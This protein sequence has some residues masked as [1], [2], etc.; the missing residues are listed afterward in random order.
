MRV[1]FSDDGR[2][3]LR[4]DWLG[5]VHADPAATVFH[6]PRYLKLYWEEFGHE[7]DLLLAFAEDGGETVGAVAFERAGSTLRFLGGTE[8][9]DYMGPVAIP[10]TEDR[11]AKEVVDALQTVD[12]WNE[13]DLRGLPED[14]PWLRRLQ[15]AAGSAGFVVD[16]GEDSVAPFVDLPATWPEYL[17]R[18]PGKL[19]H[20]LKRKHR[21]LETDAE[22]HELRFADEGTIR[23]DLDRFVGL[24]RASEGP[25]GKFMQPGM[26][27]FFRRL[28]EEFLPDGV[29]RLA[30]LQAEGADMAGAIGFAFEARFYLYNSAFDR[31]WRQLAPGMML[32]AH[33]IEDAIDSGCRVFDML[34]GD[35]DYK[36]RFGAK[37]RAAKRLAVRLAR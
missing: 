15:D 2:D 12:G 11:V 1:T 20:E 34:K 28:A 18:L 35:L 32:V 7:G 16:V 17:E 5:L 25:K 26:E 4:R 27:I 37:R 14:S 22:W 33:L 24:H 10:G 23:Q 9:T 21:R 36:Y 31:E 3:F 6:T 19:R 13:A 30:F 8:V 29:F